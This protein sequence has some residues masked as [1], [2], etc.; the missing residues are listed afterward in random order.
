[1]AS[2]CSTGVSAACAGIQREEQ[3]LLQ[4][5]YARTPDLD[6]STTFLVWLESA[7]DDQARNDLGNGAE[8]RLHCV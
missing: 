7:Q 3:A 8:D 5:V 6:Y 2:G 1:M 4:A